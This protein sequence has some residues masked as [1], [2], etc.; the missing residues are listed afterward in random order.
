[1]K[2]MLKYSFVLFCAIALSACDSNSDSDNNDNGGGSGKMTA[3]IDGTGWNAASATATKISAFGITSLTIAG[4]DASATSMTLSFV[5]VAGPGTF[6]L[7]SGNL[8][9]MSYTPDAASGPFISTVG[10]AT[11]TTL[12]DDKVKGTF[13]FEG[14]RFS[15]GATVAIVNGTFDVGYGLSLF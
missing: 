1:M 13:S 8:A 6:D 3:T 2:S 14:T 11:I 12:N 5:A 15:D 10:S 9:S 4:A 7:D